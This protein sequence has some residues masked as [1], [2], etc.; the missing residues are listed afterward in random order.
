MKKLKLVI[1]LCGVLGLVE[2]VLPF[3]GSSMLKYW[4][5]LAPAQAI[6]ITAAFA[7]PITMMLLALSRPPL[8]GW[9][10]GVALAGFVIAVIKFRVWESLAHLGAAGVHGIL[11]LGAIAVGAVGSVIALLRPEA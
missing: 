7:L 4:F 1:L 9:Q 6:V 10:A 8:Q 3:H 11:L 2:L 5:Q